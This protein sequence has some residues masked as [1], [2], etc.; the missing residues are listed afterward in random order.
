MINSILR[1]KKGKEGVKFS[2]MVFFVLGILIVGI[3]IA[4][5]FNVNIGGK[6]VKDQNITYTSNK[7]ILTKQINPKKSTGE[8][9]INVI[10]NTLDFTIGKI[11]N[12]MVN[13]SSPTGAMIVIAAIWLVFFI[14]MTD[15][16]KVSEFVSKEVAW[17]VALALSVAAANL[18]VI[19][20][21]TGKITV[22]FSYLGVFAI[23]GALGAAVIAWFAVQAGISS[24]TPW[25]LKRRLMKESTMTQIAT[26][27]IETS[28]D[29]FARF[30]RKLKRLG[31]DSN[32][33]K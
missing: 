26:H 1:N 9:A 33:N 30:A 17:I 31:E 23:Y 29:S 22:I 20:T 4:Y 11:P 21:I 13:T 5:I 3:T 15:I 10:G 7:E 24:L 19:G 14:V 16:L 32:K 8:R 25:I 28:L 6:S 2:S 18:K 27:N 12:N